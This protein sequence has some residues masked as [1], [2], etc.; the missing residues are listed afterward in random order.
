MENPM[1]ESV[2]CLLWLDFERRAKLEFQ[3]CLITSDAGLLVYCELDAAL[4][5]LQV[6][7]K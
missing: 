5:A 3:G 6:P 4:A 1:G 2:H 7:R